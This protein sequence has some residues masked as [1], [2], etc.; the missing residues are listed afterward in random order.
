M[1]AINEGAGAAA[2]P[3]EFRALF[4]SVVSTAAEELRATPSSRHLGEPNHW[5]ELAELYRRL[6][7][8]VQRRLRAGAVEAVE[9]CAERTLHSKDGQLWGR[10]DAYFVSADGIDLV[11]YKSGALSSEASP[12]DEYVEQLLF[13]AYLIQENYGQYPRSL[14]LIGRDGLVIPVAPAPGRSAILGDQLRSMLD[15]YNTAVR[16]QAAAEELAT[17]SAEGCLFCDR[18]ALCSKFWDAL[19]VLETPAWSHV[20]LGSQMGPL[21]KSARGGGFFELTVER[22][23]LSARVIKVTRVFEARFPDVDLAHRTGQRLLLTSLRYAAGKDVVVVE[24]TERTTIVAMDP[25]A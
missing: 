9:A 20:A 19:P 7:D 5:P 17:P 2:S 23:S 3:A 1:S 18:K 25:S 22:S 8:V 16:R 11:D 24:T 12:K 10:P 21:I 15:T 14:S 6:Y 13:Y 4:N